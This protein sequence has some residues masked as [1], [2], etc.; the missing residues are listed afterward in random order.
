VTIVADGNL[1]YANGTSL[2]VAN[3]NRWRVHPLFLP[4]GAAS[5]PAP[6]TELYQFDTSGT[7]PPRYL[8]AGTVP[9]WLINEYALSEWSGNLR[10]A[11]TV[12]PV[13]SVAGG[14]TSGQDTSGQDTSS[15]TVYLLRRSGATLG[16][17]GTVGGLG[18]GQRI[19]A[20]RFDGPVG[21]VVTFRQT[22][23]LYV[24]DLRDPAHPAVTGTLEI[25]GY[26]AYLH[27]A[28]NGR[29]IGVGQAAD[30]AGHVQGAQVSL[31]DVANPAAPRLVARHQ[32]RYARSSVEFDPHAFLYWPAT[33]L[34]VVPITGSVGTAK[35]GVGAP[36]PTEPTGPTGT[37]LALRISGTTMTEVGSVAHPTGVVTRSL[38]IDRTLWTVSGAGLAAD[39]LTT[40]T[41]L[42]WLPY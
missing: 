18:K 23:P 21:Y 32:V 33:G 12:S 8:A 24:L 2:Y 42:A 3:D 14:V 37:A 4:R 19:Y 39:D 28:G 30:A 5:P 13:A 7:G 1:V 15:S 36:V 9:G 25:N 29:L 38:V 22:D 16:Q 20:V 27:P 35:V 34:V 6:P 41:R 11:T 26:S 40:L 31:F 17:I 10:V